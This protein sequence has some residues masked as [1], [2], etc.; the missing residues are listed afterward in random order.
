MALKLAGSK[1]TGSAPLGSLDTADGLVPGGLSTAS[2]LEE[3]A[4]DGAFGMLAQ[5]THVSAA[6]MV[7]SSKNSSSFHGVL[8]GRLRRGAI[9]EL[10]R[11]AISAPINTTT[12][13][14]TPPPGGSFV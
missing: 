9:S 14:K 13:R 8:P 10:C 4:A 11:P 7:M 5:L 12:T 2:S 3:F 6:E 1:L